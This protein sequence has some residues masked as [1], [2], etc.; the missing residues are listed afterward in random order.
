MNVRSSVADSDLVRKNTIDDPAKPAGSRFTKAGPTMISDDNNLRDSEPSLI[1][2]AIEAFA[3]AAR[4]EEILVSCVKGLNY[5]VQ[6]ADGP[7]A[8]H[9]SQ[10]DAREL[11]SAIVGAGPVLAG[12]LG[13]TIVKDHY[14]LGMVGAFG[15]A[16]LFGKTGVEVRAEVTEPLL[17]DHF[18][19]ALLLLAEL[20]TLLCIHRIEGR[21]NLLRDIMTDRRI[22]N[23][24]KH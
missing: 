23:I 15:L 13:D 9:V 7:E 2:P 22:V 11:V 24:S 19:H 1:G 18:D 16:S 5:V 8:L 14:I 6:I 12:L 4:G 3:S 21:G 17:H 10:D 20:Q